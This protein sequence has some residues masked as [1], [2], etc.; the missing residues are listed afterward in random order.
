M[1]IRD[2]LKVLLDNKFTSN[3][4]HLFAHSM[5]GFVTEAAFQDPKSIKI[6]HVVMAAADVDQSNYVAGSTTLKNVLS[7]CTDLTAYWSSDDVALQGSRTFNKYIPL[8]LNG[9]PDPDTPASCTAVQCTTY[10]NKYAK[11]E[12]QPDDFSH[13]WYI[14]YAPT[15]PLVNDFYADMNRTLSGGP[16]PTPPPTWPT[17]ASGFVLRRPA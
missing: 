16:A 15:P 6:N 4:I 13:V 8:G 17:R 9:F 5:G 7:K 14:L 11:Y 1:L 2:C 3:N 10:Y 12:G